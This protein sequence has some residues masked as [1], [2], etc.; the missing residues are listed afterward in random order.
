[1]VTGWIVLV[2]LVAVLYSLLMVLVIQGWNKTRKSGIPSNYFPVTSLSLIIPF[3]NE[4]HRLQP[5]IA[6]LDA[7]QYPRDLLEI[8]CVDD[9]SEDD[10][11]QKLSRHVHP[12]LQ[13]IQLKGGTNGKKAA[14]RLGVKQAK[15][16]ILVFTDADCQFDNQWLMQIA[17]EMETSQAGILA[18]PVHIKGPRSFL[19]KFQELD[20]LGMQ[21]VTVAGLWFKK[22]PFANGA[23]LAIKKSFLEQLGGYPDD[24]STR[25]GDDVFL[26]EKALLKDPSSVAF[27]KSKKAIVKTSPYLS[28]EAFF[29]QRLRWASK[30]DAYEMQ[31]MVY[32]QGLVFA[33]NLVIL[34]SLL[35]GIFHLHIL[36]IGLIAFL[37]KSFWDIILLRKTAAFFNV[38]FSF[39]FFLIAALFYPFYFLVVGAMS[40]QKEQIEW[41]GRRLL[42]Y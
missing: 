24:K 11:F 29:Q 30:T 2:A 32:A 17:Y 21:G 38:R 9:H 15:G 1:M 12:C 37:I 10:T 41:K 6:S 13:V 22:L 39:P 26:M 34:A 27:L 16:D 5:L 35:L 7:V 40:F 3:R 36:I 23:N 33:F 31:E 14:L 8:I 20:F 25:S 4:S 19:A 28:W 18:G 42:F